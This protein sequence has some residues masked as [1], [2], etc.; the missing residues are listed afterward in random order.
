MPSFVSLSSQEVLVTSEQ[1]DKL[2]RKDN[3]YL[4]IG[5]TEG[6]A[7][8]IRPNRLK[9][10]IEGIGSSFTEASAFVLAHLEPEQ[11]QQVMQRAFGSEGANF[12]LCRS[13]IGS[14]DFS[15]EG[16]RSCAEVADDLTLKHFS[17][18]ADKDGFDPALYPGIKD[19]AFDLLPMIK[20]AQAIK[21]A[22]KDGPLHIIAS[23]W[24]A[25][26]WMKDNGAWFESGHAKNN[27][28]GYGGALKPEHY[29]TYAD[30]LLKFI[31]AYRAEGVNL[32]G[33]TPVNEPHGNN[34]Q[35]ESLHFTPQQ[36][37][38]FV[39]NHLGPQL[40]AQGCGELK[41]LV[42]DQNRDQM[43]EWAQILFS[44]PETVNYC[45]GLAVHWYSSTFKVY[46]QEFR[47]LHAQFPEQ[48]IIHTEGCIDDLGKD[49]PEG[50]SDPVAFKESD[51]FGN[52]DFWWNA[53]A[54]DWAYTASWDGVK[55]E[56]HPIYT[57]TH[58]YARDIIVGLNNWLNGWIDWNLVLDR[59]G[60]P[61]HAGNYCGAPIMIDTASGEVHYTP[62][63]HI[64]S[65]LSRTIRPG[66]SAV[67]CSIDR[68]GTGDD[69]LHACASINQYKMLSVQLLNTT[70]QPQELALCIDN[71]VADVTISANALQ[72]IRLQ[73]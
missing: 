48:R 1:G 4:S 45:Y 41:L 54:T 2:E 57:P 67:E 42:Y 23:A 31:H 8:R 61:N 12:S 56:D 36:Q 25:P 52:D 49:A 11:R 10:K 60:G 17:I 28:Q 32:W 58:R 43:N 22:Q 35:W 38:D 19:S 21:A 71:L 40:L 66:D 33:L 3:I 26:P 51:W 73:L 15:V 7:V 50:V 13:H 6:L 69:D 5:Q 59:E 14:C 9:Q 18:N 53:N 37:N 62:V 44:D 29:C 47:A 55:P 24:T 64:L 70:K 68:A 27:W 63:F 72:T 30:Y 65:Q 46:E 16:R 20:Q 39:K 34:G